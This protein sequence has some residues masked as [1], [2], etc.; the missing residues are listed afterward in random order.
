MTLLEVMLSMSLLVVLSAV[1]YS[2]YFNSIS[3]KS[4]GTERAS[5]L[6]LMRTVLRRISE[7]IR[8]AVVQTGDYGMGITGGSEAIEITTLRVPRRELARERS[9]QEAPAELEYDLVK[10]HYKIA[11]HPDVLHEDGWEQPLGLARIE[12]RIPRRLA[13]KRS[14]GGDEDVDPQD[15]QGGG[16][17]LELDGASEDT[18]GEASIGPEIDWE[19]L[20]APDIHYVRFCYYDGYSWWDDWVVFGENPLPQLIEVTVGFGDHPPIHDEVAD[21]DTNQQFCACL[22]K[23]PS[24]CEPLSPDE[25]STVVRVTRA[26]PLFRSRV[27]R[28]GQQLAQDLQRGE[29]SEEEESP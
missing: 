8:Q 26:D 24:D 12:K 29:G 5:D 16:R 28:E 27:S 13:A 6:R 7:E 9:T 20:Y 21:D 1:T 19:E 18:G 4:T 14:L 25:Y 3:S 23:D 17:S 15:P 11:R 22:N 10:V 2:F